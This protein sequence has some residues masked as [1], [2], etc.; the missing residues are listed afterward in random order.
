VCWR[1]YERG[2]AVRPSSPFS[3]EFAGALLMRS[4]LARPGASRAH[5]HQY[6]AILSPRE[7]APIREL[8]REYHR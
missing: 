8:A 5:L 3:P 4:P 2:L 1:T 6:L 7:R